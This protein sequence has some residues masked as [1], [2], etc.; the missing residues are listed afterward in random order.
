MRIAS[1][2]LFLNDKSHVLQIHIQSHPIPSYPPAFRKAH[3]EILSSCRR[4]Y[5]SSCL[6]ISR[7]RAEPHIEKL[8]VEKLKTRG[9][10]KGAWLGNPPFVVSLRI[11]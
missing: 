11:P 6:I 8:L 9:I 3:F 4:V 2:Q 1:K 7:K 5:C 10:E